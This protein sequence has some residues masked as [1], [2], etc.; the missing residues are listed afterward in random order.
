[1]TFRR[2]TKASP[3]LEE[4]HFFEKSYFHDSP[5]FAVV[6]SPS[7]SSCPIS[8]QPLTLALTWAWTTMWSSCAQHSLDHPRDRPQTGP[9][10]DGS[11]L[12]KRLQRCRLRSVSSCHASTRVARKGNRVSNSACKRLWIPGASTRCHASWDSHTKR[13]VTRPGRESS[14][15]TSLD[16]NGMHSNPGSGLHPRV[17]DSQRREARGRLP[18][19]SAPFHTSTSRRTASRASTTSADEPT[20]A[21]TRAP[22]SPA[23]TSCVRVATVVS[24]I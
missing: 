2:D 12:S 8:S 21:T 3:R 18:L 16:R 19:T 9:W 5:G 11:T 14:S 6:C 20:F 17:G 7:L 23:R 4:P 22:N 1:M 10:K 13:R 15:Q 24:G